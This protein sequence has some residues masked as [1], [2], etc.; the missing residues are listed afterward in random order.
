MYRNKTGRLPK[1]LQSDSKLG[2]AE[3]VVVRWMGVWTLTLRGGWC[4]CSGGS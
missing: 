4:L 2:D 1:R 3:G